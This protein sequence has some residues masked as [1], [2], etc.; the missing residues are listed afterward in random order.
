M[1]VHYNAATVDAVVSVWARLP[2]EVRKKV[3]EATNRLL[4]LSNGFGEDTT[5]AEVSGMVTELYSNLPADVQ[6][7]VME[8]LRAIIWNYDI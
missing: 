3:I 5:N 2:K 7:S 6:R 4:T 1:N 8:T